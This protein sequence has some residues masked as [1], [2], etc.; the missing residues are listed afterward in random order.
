[1][2]RLPSMTAL[3]CLDASAQLLSFTQAAVQ[4]HLTQSAVSHN[5]LQLEELLKVQIFQRKRAGLELTPAGR[6]YWQDIRPALQMIEQATEGIASAAELGAALNLSVTGSFAN[7]WL[8]PRLQGFLAKHPEVSLNLSTRVGETDFSNGDSDASI[9]FCTGERPGV[10]SQLVLEAGLRPYV[11]RDVLQGF[12]GRNF[13][14]EESLSRDELRSF[15]DT[16]QL[17]RRHAVS[18]AW[19]GWLTL[20]GIDSVS[21]EHLEAGPWYTLMS[22]ALNGALGGI[23]VALLPAFM[24]KDA[25]QSRRLVCLSNVDWHSTHAYY[26]RRPE[27][28]PV[29]PAFSAFADWLISTSSEIDMRS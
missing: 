9:E 11:A 29:P 13:G 16:H 6:K 12:L 20:A 18:D 8:M 24:A 10:V 17:I 4:L 3:K 2:K 27:W 15:L 23:G 26:L 21:E 7:Y 14:D 28:R 1:M 22:M 19:P 5:I 25:L